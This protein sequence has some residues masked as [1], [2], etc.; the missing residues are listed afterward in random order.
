M[1]MLGVLFDVEL[2]VKHCI[3]Y[4]LFWVTPLMVVLRFY[5][6]TAEDKYQNPANNAFD[7]FDQRQKKIIVK[8]EKYSFLGKKCPKC[9]PKQFNGNFYE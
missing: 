1:H 7:Q 3:T 2:F 5:C 8:A 4:R 6:S 9:L